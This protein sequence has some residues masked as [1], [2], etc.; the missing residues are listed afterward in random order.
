MSSGIR[1]ARKMPFRNSIDRSPV[2]QEARFEEVRK[3]L[4]RREKLVLEAIECQKSA[5]LV[6]RRDDPL[7]P[8]Y[9]AHV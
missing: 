5:R 1:Y 2:L 9:I 8:W 7:K 3:S 4:I 6:V